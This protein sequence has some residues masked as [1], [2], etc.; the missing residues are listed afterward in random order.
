VFGGAE[1]AKIA[2]IVMSNDAFSWRRA[3]IVQRSGIGAEAGTL[4]CGRDDRR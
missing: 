3:G 2:A 1:F 4:R